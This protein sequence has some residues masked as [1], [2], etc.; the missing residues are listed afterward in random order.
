[1]SASGLLHTATSASYG[2]NSDS[3]DF[4][5]VFCFSNGKIIM[6]MRVLMPMYCTVKRIGER[7]TDRHQQV[8]WSNSADN[9]R[10][11]YAR[12]FGPIRCL[13]SPRRIRPRISTCT[14]TLSMHALTGLMQQQGKTET[15]PYA[16]TIQ[17]STVSDGVFSAVPGRQ[18]TFYGCLSSCCSCVCCYMVRA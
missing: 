6:I 2:I 7:N 9:F 14:S 18:I 11:V 8:T 1:M 17:L 3:N 16:G 13:V 10:F 5:S 4:F 15:R 12:Y